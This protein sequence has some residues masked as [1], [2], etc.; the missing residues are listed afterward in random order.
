MSRSTLSRLLILSLS[1][2]ALC[3][4]TA[5]AQDAPAAALPIATGDGSAESL[6]SESTRQLEARTAELDRLLEAFVQDGA[7]RSPPAVQA[8]LGAASWLRREI[9][10]RDRLLARI[11]EDRQRAEAGQ[12][13][14]R[15]LR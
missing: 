8:L 13:T 7:D 5:S 12:A 9:I 11:Q 10:L 2:F 6:V 14:P 4:F 1:A 3:T 15:P